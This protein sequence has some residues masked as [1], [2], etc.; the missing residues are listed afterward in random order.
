MAFADWW[1][2]LHG[3]N[4]KIMV[5]ALTMSVLASPAMAISRY[6]IGGRTCGDVQALISQERA[7]VLR[8]P[9][10]DGRLTLYDRYV[11]DG[12]QCD[13][14]KQATRTYVPTKDKPACPVYNCQFPTNLRP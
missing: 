13:F 8:Y 4:M 12:D 3:W 6:D 2:F 1:Y 7:V 10:R 9:S 11:V 5:A 14:G